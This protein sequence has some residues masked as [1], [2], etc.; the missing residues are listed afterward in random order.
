MR[1]L[2]VAATA[3]EIPRLSTGA[4]RSH[5]VD[6]LVTGVG[7]VATAAWTSRALT[8]THYDVA[9]NLGVC[10]TFD[11]ALPLGTV[12][13]VTRDSLPELGAEDGPSFLTLQQLGLAA[14]DGVLH[15]DAPPSNDALASLPCVGGVTVNTVHGRDE[16]I[17]AV[18]DRFRPQVESME[19]AGFVY[20]CRIG[21]V[22]YA[23][24][25]AVS[26]VVERRNREA[27]RLD[28]AVRN[29]NDVALQILDHS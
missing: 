3:L 15:N 9:Y 28:L 18:V 6:V 17:A 11:R 5:H 7:M 21:G 19:G 20:A 4:R 27:W 26:N 22:P 23:Q 16:S 14:D 24:V 13:H 29:L 2:V 12:V 25:R 1:I 10:G 8:G